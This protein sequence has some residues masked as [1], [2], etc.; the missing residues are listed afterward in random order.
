MVYD[1]PLGPQVKEAKGVSHPLLVG[2]V[3]KVQEI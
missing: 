1:T 3:I 2:V